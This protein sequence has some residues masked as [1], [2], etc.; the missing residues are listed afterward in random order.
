M[1]EPVSDGAFGRKKPTRRRA[2]AQNFRFQFFSSLNL[3]LAI[4]SKVRKYAASCFLLFFAFEFLNNSHPVF[5]TLSLSRADDVVDVKRLFNQSF[6]ISRAPARASDFQLANLR[7]H[8]TNQLV[9]AT[10]KMEHFDASKSRRRAGISAGDHR[11]EL[12]N[13]NK[14]SDSNVNIHGKSFLFGFCFPSRGG[15]RWS[16][17]YFQTSSSFI[18]LIS[19][20]LQIKLTTSLFPNHYKILDVLYLAIIASRPPSLRLN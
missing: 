14:N 9:L 16:K 8:R 4:R 17:V 15:R 6:T 18:K 19:V 20:D 13:R 7:S 2:R 12:Q 1:L 5:D 11:I 3:D 10:S